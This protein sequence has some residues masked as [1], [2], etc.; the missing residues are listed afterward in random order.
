MKENHV[1]IGDYVLFLNQRAVKNEERVERG[2]ETFGDHLLALIGDG[3]PIAIDH[4]EL[5]RRGITIEEE[6]LR[7][8]KLLGKQLDLAYFRDEQA[9]K[10]GG[11]ERQANA[12]NN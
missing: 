11:R 3:M 7:Q 10:V 12:S 1:T 8:E 5:K 2:E 4:K 6:M 9:E